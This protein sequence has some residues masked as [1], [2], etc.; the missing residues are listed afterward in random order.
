MSEIAI[1]PARA[2]DRETVLAF[3]ANTWEWGDYIERVWEQWQSDSTGLLLV[4]LHDGQPVGIVHLQM[5]SA[6]DAWQEGMR[7]DPA[8][9]KQGIAR[10]LSME[11]SA[12]AM[13]RGATT[14]R[15][16]TESTNEASIHMVE[17]GHFRRAGAFAP[18]T[19]SAVTGTLQHNT[20]LEEPVLATLTDQDEIIA[21]L[22]VS[23][24]FPAVG[25]L[26]YA[27]FTGYR[28]SDIL[29]TEKIQAQ[30]IYLLRRWERLDGLAIAEPRTERQGK[31]LFIGYIDGT[32]ESISLLAYAL[33]C[34]LSALGLE[35]VRAAVPDL[36]MVR[37]AFAGAEYEWDGHIFYTYERSLE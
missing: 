32:T 6:T 25:G 23:S 36:M 28:I 20:G 11:A 9:R 35:Q 14:V 5:L 12:E 33:R 1:R 22:D 26:Y 16:L 31:H 30:Q 24:N 17:Q 34:R 27:G 3:C 8:Y 4:A 21:Y 29:L 15:L 37:D 18:Y 19:A 10:Q 13:R 2:E 7:V